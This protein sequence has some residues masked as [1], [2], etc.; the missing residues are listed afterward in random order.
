MFVSWCVGFGE[1]LCKDQLW[2]CRYRCGFEFNRDALRPIVIIQHRPGISNKKWYC[3]Q[4]LLREVVVSGSGTKVYQSYIGNNLTKWNHEG[5]HHSTTSLNL[6]W[7]L[8]FLAVSRT[9]P[10]DTQRMV[11]FAW[12]SC[13]N[14]MSLLL[15]QQINPSDIWGCKVP[16]I[17]LHSKKTPSAFS[18][19]IKTPIK[20][21]VLPKHLTVTPFISLV[22]H[23][24]FKPYRWISTP[25]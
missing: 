1:D 23:A 14:K 22:P 9:S 15:N 21:L 18:G 25:F 11:M 6:F 8:P 2:T 16:D 17:L 20:P 3:G 5:P 19:V 10:L 24:L 12:T 4:W 13:V 7:T